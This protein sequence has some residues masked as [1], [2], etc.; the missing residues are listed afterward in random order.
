MQQMLM[1][2]TRNELK[3]RYVLADSWFSSSENMQFIHLD[4]NK[5]FIFALKSNPVA[6]TGWD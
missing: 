2:C 3:Y 4:L 1:T 5:H 6:H